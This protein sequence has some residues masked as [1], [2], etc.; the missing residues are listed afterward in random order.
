MPALREPVAQPAAQDILDQQPIPRLR[1]RLAQE[2][3]RVILVEMMQEERAH[4]H[5]VA[6][7]QWFARDLERE[8]TDWSASVC[9]G[10]ARMRNGLLARIAA[11]QLDIERSLCRPAR[12]RHEHVTAPARDIEHTHR[13]ARM[14]PGGSQEIRPHQPARLRHGID[15][16][17]AFK[18]LR[19]ARRRQ[20]GCI[21]DLGTPVPPAEIGPLV[22]RVHG[23]LLAERRAIEK[24]TL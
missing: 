17:Q 23:S 3:D 21:H 24:H 8:E 4:D 18:R 10:L 9:G 19:E 20:I 11:R 2:R 1:R 15:E 7:R 5:V 22:M 14:A 13:L 6:L 12:E 16:T